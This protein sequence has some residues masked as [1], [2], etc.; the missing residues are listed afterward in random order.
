VAGRLSLKPSG[1][2]GATRE[3]PTTLDV[4]ALLSAGFTPR[5][6]RQYVLKLTARCDLA[7]DY[8]YVFAMADEGWR[9]KPPVLL[10]TAER[11]AQ[12]VIEHELSDVSVV[13]HGGE[14]LLAGV[15]V[16]AYAATMVRQLLPAGTRVDLQVQTNGLR[17]DEPMLRV[18]AEHGIRVGVSL[19]GDRAAH[20]RH[21]RHAGGRPSF[22]AVSASLRRLTAGFPELFAGLLCTIDVRN[23]PLRTYEALLEFSPP[24]VDLLLPHGTWSAPPPGIA[25]DDPGR[26]TPYGDWLAA[27]FDRWFPVAR[28]E[29]SIRFFDELLQL[30]LGGSSRAEA[31]GL[32]P[33]AVVVVDTDGAIEQVDTLRAAYDGAAD[34]GLSVWDAD[35]DVALTQPGVVARQLG[36][37]ALSSTCRGCAV[38][39]VCGGGYFPHRYRRGS[40]FLNPSVYCQDLSHVIDHMHESIREH[41]A[42]LVRVDHTP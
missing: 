35:F 5:P 9:S 17:L 11:I 21:R 24:S 1:A 27:V 19:D 26:P 34:L 29:T 41:V 20:D 42:A 39:Q 15:D 8:C 10:R 36:M 40:G 33:S 4:A 7:C 32:S 28:R 14:P 30:S 3:W 13:L 23:D 6:F 22:D 37:T 16:I 12:H 2:T 18:L 25:A 31:I 38:V